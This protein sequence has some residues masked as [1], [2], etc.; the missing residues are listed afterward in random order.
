VRLS[1]RCS[2]VRR[3]GRA[4]FL[5]R[6]QRHLVH[7]RRPVALATYV[8]R[9]L[10]V[11][12]DPRVETI[13]VSLLAAAGLTWLFRRIRI[14]PADGERDGSPAIGAAAGGEI[15][16]KGLLPAASDLPP[17]VRTALQ[18]S[19]TGLVLLVL[20]YPL[21]FTVRAYAISG[22]DT[23]VHTA[24][25]IGASMLV[26]SL[27]WLILR[28]AERSGRR[29]WQAWPWGSGPGTWWATASD[30]EHSRAWKLQ[31]EFWV[32]WS[33]SAGRSRRKRRLVDPSGLEDRA[34]R[35]QLELAEGA[36]AAVRVS[37]RMAECPRVY[38]W[39]RLEERRT[40][41]T[42]TAWRVDDLLGS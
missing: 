12:A 28:Y 39:S 8:Y 10:Q 22:R 40:G 27:V 21:T 24:G 25:V 2:A 29:K 4:V 7:I 11:V 13:A 30:S 3:R 14:G 34:D 1:G 31:R 18:L 41:W 33:P 20:A 16:A 5:A 36:R 37:R 6:R 15:S 17:D 23:R 35:R 19:L 9:P 26:G 38:R 42:D 32:S